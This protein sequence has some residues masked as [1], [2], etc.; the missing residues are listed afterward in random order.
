MGQVF[1]GYVGL[2]AAMIAASTFAKEA[3][4]SEVNCPAHPVQHT[5]TRRPSWSTSTGVELMVSGEPHTT[6]SLV[7][8]VGICCAIVRA[9]ASA[10]A[11]A[12]DCGGLAGGGAACCW[13][14]PV[15]S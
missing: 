12:I 15:F 2:C 14:V 13:A 10:G 7:G 1:A 9:V 5:R 6:Q 11:A 3:A 4:G 8:Y